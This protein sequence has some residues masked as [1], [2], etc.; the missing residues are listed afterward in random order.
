MGNYEPSTEFL[1]RLSQ[2][3]RNDPVAPRELSPV[4]LRMVAKTLIA[5]F[6]AVLFD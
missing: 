5:A 3:F 6:N 2:A 1:L 4:E